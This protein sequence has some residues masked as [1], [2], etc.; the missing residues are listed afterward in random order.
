MYNISRFLQTNTS[1]W[2]NT[3]CY[4]STNCSQFSSVFLEAFKHYIITMSSSLYGNHGTYDSLGEFNNITWFYLFQKLIWRYNFFLIQA[5]DSIV[6]L[7]QY[8]CR[9]FLLKKLDGKKYLLNRQLQLRQK[10]QIKYFIVNEAQLNSFTHLFTQ[11]I[12][13]F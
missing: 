12:Y 10:F 3:P 1:Y 11:Q 13:Q 5:L 8:K 2:K 7:T 6:L 4:L 9:L